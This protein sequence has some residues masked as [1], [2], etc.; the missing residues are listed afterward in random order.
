[1]AAV[2]AALTRFLQAGDILA[3]WGDLGAG[4]TTFARH[5][6]AAAGVRET[7]PSPTFTLV[8]TYIAGDGHTF[9]HFDLYRLESS[10]DAWELDIEDAFADGIS[11]IE[12]PDRL[13][14]LLPQPA[15][16]NLQLMVEDDSHRSLLL[17]AGSN[18]TGRWPD[19]E[20]AL[21]P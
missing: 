5:L 21:R 17:S 8:Q 2:A 1:M 16:L 19:L 10:E 4:K 20:K 6:L 14:R 9:W 12:W 18:W 3:L 15:T 7:V 11:L 13:G